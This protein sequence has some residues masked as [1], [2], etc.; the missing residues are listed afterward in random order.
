MATKSTKKTP[1]KSK[2]TKKVPSKKGTAK[3][4]PAKPAA[5]KPAVAKKPAASPQKKAQQKS[6]TPAAKSNPAQKKSGA[7]QKVSAKKP[8]AS[9]LKPKVQ[10]K[11]KA[12]QKPAKSAAKSPKGSQAPQKNPEEKRASTPIAEHKRKLN[13]KIR[14][15]IHLS[16]EQGF[17]TTQDINKHLTETLSRPE[18]FE[19]V[20]NILENLD[21]AILDNEEEVDN[22]KHRSDENEERQTRA[23][24]TETLDDPVRMYLRQMGQ[25]PLLTRDEEVSISNPWARHFRRNRQN[26]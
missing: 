4:T 16:K 23:L 11:P 6:A 9:P 2:A 25:V 8:A 1:P 19:N 5:K 14:Q 13:D 15:L 22:F 10:Q 26:L 24:Q 12:P 20:I 7:P 21:V 17:L 3:T 18:E